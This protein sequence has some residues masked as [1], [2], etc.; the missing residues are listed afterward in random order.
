MAT[1]TGDGYRKGS[2]K[3]R[4]ELPHP[5]DENKSIKRDAVT[6]KFMDAKDRQWKGVADEVDGRRTKK[7]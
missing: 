6:G 7:D 5:Q 3:S 4:T 2:V 1:N